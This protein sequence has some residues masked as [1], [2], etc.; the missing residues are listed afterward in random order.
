MNRRTFTKNIS[1]LGFVLSSI[2]NVFA[3]TSAL[4]TEELIGK[5][6]PQLFG[7]DYQLRKEA[8]DAF[9]KMSK[10]AS[11]EDI[12]IKIV[13]SY[14]SFDHQKTIFTKKYKRF[15]SQGLLPKE[16]ISKIIEY[17]T[18]PGTSRHHWGTDMD[19]VDGRFIN[20][21]SLLSAKNFEKNAPFYEM[22][23]WLNEHATT[24]GFYEV[25]TDN[26]MRKGFKYEPWHFSYKP[27]SKKYLDAYQEIDIVK[28]LKEEHLAGSNYFTNE[29][30]TKYIQEHILDINPELL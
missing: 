26:P 10:K 21:P 19:I 14:R 11:E 17:S 29:F 30:I 4:P 27:L 24:Y 9:L 20:T 8:H 7:N 23:Q 2:P 25:Y 16:V 22:K 12:I 6:T 3:Q 18:I 1:L 28:L 15:T 5:G 13:S